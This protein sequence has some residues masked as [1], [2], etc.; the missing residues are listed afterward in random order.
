M[1]NDPRPIDSTNDAKL[2]ITPFENFEFCAD[3]TSALLGLAEVVPCSR[4]LPVLFAKLESAV[5][6]IALL[7]L[8]E[9]GNAAVKNGTWLYEYIPAVFRSY[10]FLLAQ[11]D[12]KGENFAVCLERTAQNISETDGE[13]LFT[14]D[15]APAPLLEQAKNL[16][17]NLHTEQAR[18]QLLGNLLVEKELLVPF[19]ITVRQGEEQQAIPLEGLYFV[20]EKKLNDLSDEDFCDLRAKGVLPALYAH[21]MSLGQINRI[22]PRTTES[23]QESK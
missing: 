15:G 21:L 23:E 7:G 8:P 18:A 22:M 10:P 9:K 20:N 4:E 13:P 2:R 17:Q 6:P 5:A 14:E 3:Q 16:L 19:A 12:E 11:T 1:F